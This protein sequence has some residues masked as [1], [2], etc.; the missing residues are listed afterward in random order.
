MSGLLVP[1][2]IHNKGWMVVALCFLLEISVS[3]LTMGLVSGFA[4]LMSMLLH[5]VGHI[6]G[7]RAFGVPVREFGI[8][9][10]G[11]YVV[12]GRGNCGR[13][14]ALIS[15]AG[16]LMNLALVLP[17]IFLPHIGIQ[18]ATSNLSL[19]VMNL[20][21]IPSSDGLRIARSLWGPGWPSNATSH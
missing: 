12:R 11:A 7:A 18:I 19:C 16:P 20:L 13:D 15:L 10:Y 4:L 6:L 8:S 1:F 2:R 3:G 21:P 5:E 9:V 17:C 14:D